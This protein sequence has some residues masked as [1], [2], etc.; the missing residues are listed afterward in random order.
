M[1][2][3][4][5]LPCKQLAE[6]VKHFWIMDSENKSLSE[7]VVPTGEIQILFHYKKPFRQLLPDGL[8]LAQ[9]QTVV[10]GQ[11]T[12]FKDVQTEP[13]CGVIGVVLFPF[14]ANT[15]LPVPMNEITDVILHPA[16]I[17]PGFRQLEDQ[18]LECA[19]INRRMQLIED[20]LLKRLNDS[21]IKLSQINR[22]HIIRQSV[23]RIME[24]KGCLGVTNLLKEIQVPERQFQRL[25]RSH[26]G[27]SPRH[28]IEITRFNHARALMDS[29]L[30]LSRIALEA[31]YYDQPQ[32]NRIFKRY[33]GYSPTQYR[34]VCCNA[35]NISEK[36]STPQY[37]S[38]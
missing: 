23:L 19:G 12:S 34:A 15:L 22:Y 14:A 11:T 17:L 36:S 13:E 35:E 28:F 6:Y 16:E 37:L 21:H 27:I 7:R 26:V 38:E 32:F 8:T 31:G 4:I 33:A 9:P 29:S 10:S 30:S 1:F 24:R 18:L 3:G 20:F 5:R 25:F 2:I